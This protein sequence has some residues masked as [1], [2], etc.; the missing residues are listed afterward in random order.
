V[1]SGAS[2]SL[3]A[4]ADDEFS[5][6]GIDD[7]AALTLVEAAAKMQAAAER[8]EKI[9]GLI[10]EAQAAVKAIKDGRKGTGSGRPPACGPLGSGAFEAAN[11]RLARLQRGFLP[12]ED[13]HTDRRTQPQLLAAAQLH[14]QDHPGAG[15]STR[16]EHAQ[17]RADLWDDFPARGGGADGGAD[18]DDPDGGDGG[19]GGGGGGVGAWDSS[20]DDDS[21]RQA[22]LHWDRQQ[23][24]WLH[25]LRLWPMSS[26]SRGGSVVSDRV[27]GAAVV[28]SWTLTRQKLRGGRL[29]GSVRHQSARNKSSRAALQLQNNTKPLTNLIIHILTTSTFWSFCFLEARRKSRKQL[30]RAYGAVCSGASAPEQRLVLLLPPQ[31]ENVGP[32]PPRQR[33]NPFLFFL[34]LSQHGIFAAFWL[35]AR[36]LRTSVRGP[37]S[38]LPAGCHS[39]DLPPRRAAARPSLSQK[40]SP[41]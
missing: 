19:G 6:G 11:S 33:T 2:S 38:L 26:R 1:S 16:H 21:R 4:E 17:L 22:A 8:E 29:I 5:D 25:L 13:E 32:Q 24:R 28:G 20:D 3:S 10:V 40:T 7:A 39:E 14:P 30:C 31:H 34:F 12:G 15:N 41:S 23:Q 18:H 35:F 9:V 27:S 37:P 36:F